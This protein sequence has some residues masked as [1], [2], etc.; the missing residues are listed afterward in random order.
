MVDLHLVRQARLH[1]L[2]ARDRL[3]G[4]ATMDAWR[5][6]DK[7]ISLLDGLAF[8]RDLPVAPELGERDA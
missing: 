5:E 3:R 2:R 7:A 1:V 6:L 4:N 8:A